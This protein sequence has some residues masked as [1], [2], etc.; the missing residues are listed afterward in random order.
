M[1]WRVILNALTILV[2]TAVF[3][4][5]I[6]PR[7]TKPVPCDEPIAY[8][9]GFFD[10]R[11]SISQKDFLK[12]LAQAE[13]IWEKP[14]GK[15]LFVYESEQGELAVNLIY[16]YRQKVTSTL[17][18]LGSVVKEDKATY[19]LLQAR[20]IGLKKEYDTAKSVYD[21]MVETFNDKNAAYQMQVESWNKGKRNSKEQF[22]QLE[23]ERVDLEREAEK[24]KVLEGELNE[25]VKEINELVGALNR[26]AESL[27]LN[28]ETYNT[29]G[30]SRG[31]TFTGGVYYSAEGNGGID[32]YEFESHKK[33][34]RILTHELGHALG[35]EHVDDPEA[36]MYYLNRGEARVLTETDLAALRAL[37][38]TR[39]IKN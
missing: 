3:V 33:L 4:V 14:I 31:E 23:Q 10:R 19:D 8:T 20:Y 37:C 24:L 9:L 28:V 11:F 7:F 5:W 2:F 39:D 36:I 30:A 34:V 25:V 1:S 35:L 22:D 13:A 26:I 17:S 27:N 6:Y 18:G 21:P 38:Y 12:A 32:I 15:E 16:D 29:I